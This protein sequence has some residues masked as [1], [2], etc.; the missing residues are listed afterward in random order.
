MDPTAIPRTSPTPKLVLSRGMKVAGV[1][2]SLMPLV[3]ALADGVLSWGETTALGIV[4]LVAIGVIFVGLTR[5]LLRRLARARTA[6]AQR[7]GSRALRV[8]TGVLILGYVALVAV[9]TMYGRDL[10]WFL[11]IAL[12]VWV[13]GMLGLTILRSRAENLL[14]ARARPRAEFGFYTSLFVLGIG[15][16]GLGA[17]TIGLAVNA[18]RNG[19]LFVFATVGVEALGLA[20]LGALLLVARHVVVALALLGIGIMAIGFGV[21]SMVGGDGLFGSGVVAVGGA[22]LISS[23]ATLKLADPWTA[24]AYFITGAAALYATFT[25][26]NQGQWILA[27]A[28]FLVGAV[29]CAATAFALSIS[30]KDISQLFRHPNNLKPWSRERYTAIAVAAAVAV[31]AASAWLAITW[32]DGRGPG[33]FAVGGITFGL[34]AVEIALVVALAYRRVPVVPQVRR[35]KRSA[36]GGEDA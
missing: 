35:A 28:L 33:L 17:A 18:L 7:T 14:S 21:G 11:W 15:I 19:D 31:A 30:D 2:L 24:L 34:L 16:L 8:M 4:G 25:S 1:G 5:I 3:G 6:G 32:R 26:W 29:L 36:V 12:V 20:I 9:L 10:A 13:I 22:T 27:F 23:V